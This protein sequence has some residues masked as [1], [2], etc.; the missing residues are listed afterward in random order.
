M[1]YS[2]SGVNELNFTVGKQYQSEYTNTYIDID[3]RCLFSSATENYYEF[4]DLGCSHPVKLSE[5]SIPISVT[6]SAGKYIGVG[7]SISYTLSRVDS[8]LVSN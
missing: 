4:I 2:R 8:L 7:L 1:D 6:F 3:L 5:H